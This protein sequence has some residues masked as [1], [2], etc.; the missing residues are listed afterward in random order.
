MIETRTKSTNL[1][2]LTRLFIS[3]KKKKKK[4]IMGKHV[5]GFVCSTILYHDISI[6]EVLSDNVTE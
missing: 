6:F 4:A 5:D 1:D 2:I 3:K